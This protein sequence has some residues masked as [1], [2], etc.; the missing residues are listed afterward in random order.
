MTTL[1]FDAGNSRIKWAEVQKG[2]LGTMHAADLSDLAPLQKWLARS[3]P[4]ERVA[5][6]SVAGPTIERRL[7]AALKQAG[8]AAPELVKSSK[9]AAGVHNGYRD[10]WRLG[11]DRWA[12]AV[13]AWTRAGR[14]RTVCAVSIG[15]ALTIDLVD[16]DGY[17]RGGLI[18]P[19]PGMM[20]G[21]LLGKTHGIATRAAS[22]GKRRAAP[23]TRPIPKPL[24][25]NTQDAIESGCLAAAAAV[26]DR[27][28]NQLTRGLGVRPVVFL[29]GGAAGRVAPL[30]IGACKPCPELVLRGVAVLAD[31]PLRP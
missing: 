24:A 16:Q 10:A 20:L 1:L 26:I 25:D 15:T 29:T 7:R 22:K 12:G 6:V 2:R 23:D 3:S 28:V 11:D 19:G 4:M 30:L 21:S 18:A 31:V 27:T 13:A 17:H 8:H 9:E 5:G 14:Y